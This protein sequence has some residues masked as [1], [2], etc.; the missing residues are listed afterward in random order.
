[1]RFPA[2]VAVALIVAPAASAKTLTLNWVEQ[3]SATYYPA[4]MTFKVKSVTT[5]AH[6]WSVRASVTNR[7]NTTI[8]LV[9]AVTI[10]SPHYQYPFSL[11]FAPVCKPPAISCQLEILAATYFRSAKPTQ[12][13]SGK[14]WT[15]TFGGPGLPPRQKL[16][17]VGFGEFVVGKKTFSYITTHAFKL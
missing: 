12:L 13:R 9:K 14:T 1:M 2:V 6:A 17:N 7:S 4:T 16:I 11:L 15:G 5:G 3:A 8:R 10:A